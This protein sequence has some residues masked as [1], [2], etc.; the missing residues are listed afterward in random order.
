MV[1]EI[2]YHGAMKNLL[3]VSIYMAVQLVPSKV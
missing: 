3:I 1:I 2:E